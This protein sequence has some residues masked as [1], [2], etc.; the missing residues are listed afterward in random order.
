[1]V[2]PDGPLAAASQPLRVAGRSR[3][4]PKILPKPRFSATAE[5]CHPSELRVGIM[6]YVRACC[7]AL[8]CIKGQSGAFR[9][10]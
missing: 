6:D 7:T 10:E 9:F 2:A 4:Y 1:M 5:V 3:P 8:G